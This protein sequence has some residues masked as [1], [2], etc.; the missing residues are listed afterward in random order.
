MRPQYLTITLFALLLATLTACGG[1]GK[2]TTSTAPAD[3]LA[4]SIPSFNADSAYAGIVRQ[5]DF[6]PRVPGTEAHRKAAA[7]IAD[8]FRSYGLEVEEQH[9]KLKAY[10]GTTFDAVNIT[11]RYKPELERRI[12]LCAH[13]DSR[14]W[15]DNDPDPANHKKPV[16]GA[17]D[18]A[19][20][21][22]VMLELARTLS[23]QNLNIGI[24]FLA[25]DAEDYG[26]AQWDEA[27]H[28]GETT[29]TW[30]LGSQHWSEAARANGYRPLFGVLLDMVGG[31]DARFYREG[32]S[33][34][35]A[36][37][38][39]SMVWDAAERAG[40]GNYFLKEDGT[41]ITDDHEVI[42]RVAGIP[43][44]D[45]IPYYPNHP[46]STFGPVWHT[47]N[48]TPEHIDRA[49]LKA[50]GQTMLRVLYEMQ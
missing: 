1:S 28:T 38:I 40:Y 50:V 24:D 31:K 2:N 35:Y 47:V 32:F 13:W 19:S 18:G 30:C 14:P 12:L 49:T 26:V 10:N 17:N 48:D 29:H 25:L 39:V 34:R 16:M 5:C 3:T 42:N 20:G 7:Y 45:I 33:M 9:A 44:I 41:Y 23:T 8:A 46:R 22:A 15:A 37:G 27:N 36:S 11:A 43:C 6:G 4:A 21:V